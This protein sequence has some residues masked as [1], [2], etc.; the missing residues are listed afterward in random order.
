ML[1]SLSLLLDKI[2]L[3]SAA[4]FNRCQTALESSYWVPYE[5]KRC[6]R[7]LGLNRKEK[8]VV[9]VVVVVS[10]NGVGMACDEAGK[11]TCLNGTYSST[12]IE[13]SIHYWST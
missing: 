11:R 1:A 9:V 13:N 5:P 6:L 10:I 12:T 3:L 8:V 4:R 2:W 7:M